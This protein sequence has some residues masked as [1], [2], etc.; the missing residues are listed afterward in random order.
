MYNLWRTFLL[1]FCIFPALVYAA[2]FKEGVDYKVLSQPLPVSQTDKIEVNTIFWYGCP[3]CFDLAKMQAHWK[4][5]QGND[6][7]TLETPVIFGRPWQAHAQLFYALEQ[8]ELH[9][10]SLFTIFD[11]VQSQGKRLDNEKEMKAFLKE[12]FGVKPEEFDRVYDSFGVRNQSQKAAALTRGAQ[13]MG[14]PAIIVSGR[15]VVD[16]EKA[17]GLENMLK[18]ADFLIE[19]VRKEQGS[20]SKKAMS[21]KAK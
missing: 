19:K 20:S 13:L 12:Q 14:V 15:Y 16:P 10:K 1:V 7:K 4:K 9:E 17:G 2:A 8:L 5:R 18:I 6:V 11:A 3:H 21:K